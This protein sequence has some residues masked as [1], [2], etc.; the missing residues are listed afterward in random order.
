MVL[1]GMVKQL[2][3]RCS[4]NSTVAVILLYT[5]TLKQIKR[6]NE[7]SLIAEIN[8]RCKP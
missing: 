4:K 1:A 8:N 5:N 3:Q 7:S 2:Y 6:C